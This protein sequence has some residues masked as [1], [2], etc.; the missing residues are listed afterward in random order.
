MLKLLTVLF[1][2][3]LANTAF[4]V[5]PANTELLVVSAGL[6]KFVPDEDRRAVFHIKT[7]KTVGPS[8]NALHQLNGCTLEGITHLETRIQRIT[9]GKARI[10]CPAAAKTAKKLHE[11]D[12]KG[13]ILGVD[14][15]TGLRVTCKYLPL[16]SI[17]TLEDGE[18][19]FFLVSGVAGN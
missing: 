15:K 9:I 16:C 1:G 7:S 13:Q 6:Q 12:V 19:G 18:S 10:K 4:A 11:F 2:M 17:A 14:H 5:L 8:G 3:A